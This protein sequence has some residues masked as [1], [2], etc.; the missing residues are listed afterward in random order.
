MDKTTKI[1]IGIIIAVVVVWGGYALMRKP[2]QTSAETIKIGISLPMTGEAASYG[3]GTLAGAQL[4]VKEINDAGGI[5]GRKIELIIEDDKC[6]PTGGVNALT[7]L[8]NADKVVAVAGPMCS[9]AAGASLPIAQKAGVPTVLWGSAPALTKVGDYIFRT[10]PSDASQGKFIAEYMV[11]TMKKNKVAVIYVK[12]D[13]GQGI[14][15]VFVDR[16][17]ELGGEVVF[18]EGI[19]QDAKDARTMIAKAKASS[20]DA[21]YLPIYPAN[22]AVVLKQIK[23]AGIALPLLGSDAFGGKEVWQIKEADGIVYVQA[24]TNNPEDFQKKVKEAT[25]KTAN[26][27]T[28]YGYDGIMVIAEAIKRAG[29]TDAAAMKNALVTMKYTKSVASSVIEFDQDR[30]LKE[31]AFDV[32]VIKNKMGVKLQ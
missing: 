28:P 8:V 12:N 24:R 20:P 1:V 21:I 9:S 25:G 14:A 18:R 22:A 32:M 30:N 4:A 16:F 13:W 31:V 6:E 29:S 11:N 27:V 19:T 23:E 15:D 2:V 10:Y 3:E 26:F 7:K 5:D 17:K